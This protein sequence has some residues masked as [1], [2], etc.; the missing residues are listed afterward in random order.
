MIR[1]PLI[2]QRRGAAL[3]EA[4]IVVP[5]LIILIGIAVDYSRIFFNTV[6]IS[7]GARNG[8]LH[9]FDPL[10]VNQSNYS[11]TT[12]ASLADTTNLSE[13]VS[14]IQST[15]TNANGTQDVTVKV[16]TNFSTLSNWLI[17][18]SMKKIERYGVIRKAQLTPDP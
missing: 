17:L 14:V 2:R 7:G 6:T 1:R 8:T 5:I 13:S 18:P 10:T 16:K 12:A 4:A 15:T 9:E 11:S 3:V